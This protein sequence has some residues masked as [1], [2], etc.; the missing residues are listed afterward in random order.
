VAVAVF[1][2]T[3][4]ETLYIINNII[5]AHNTL[6][7]KSNKYSLKVIIRGSFKMFPE[8]LYLRK[9]QISEIV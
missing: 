8:S 1:R 2:D 3:I 6:E 7:N 5:F 4:K 9:I